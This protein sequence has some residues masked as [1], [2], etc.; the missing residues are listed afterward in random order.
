MTWHLTSKKSSL[1]AYSRLG[2]IWSLQSYPPF[3]L[4]AQIFAVKKYYCLLFVSVVLINMFHPQAN[5]FQA[6]K[7]S[8]LKALKKLGSWEY[9]TLFMKHCSACNLLK[10]HL[11]GWCLCCCSKNV[12]F[13]FFYHKPCKPSEAAKPQ[14][15][16]TRDVVTPHTNWICSVS[17]EASDVYVR[18]GFL[19]LTLFFLLSFFQSMILELSSIMKK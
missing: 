10:H 14:G 11:I 3:C 4:S 7:L 16:S 12:S 9:V 8:P 19:S 13:L 5:T 15:S 2:N 6:E 1:V 17:V 18:N